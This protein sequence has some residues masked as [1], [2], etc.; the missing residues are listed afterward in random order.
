M[1]RATRRGL[2]G[3]GLAGGA[4]FGLGYGVWKRRTFGRADSLA[5]DVS[6]KAISAFDRTK[7]AQRRFGLLTFRSGLELTS[8]APGFGGWSALWRDPIDPRLVAVSDHGQWL[9]ARIVYGDRVLAGLADAR[10]SPV[11]GQDGAPLGAGG[12]YDCESLAIGGGEAFVGVERT[13]RVLRFAWEASGIGARG[14]PMTLPEE[15]GRQPRNRGIEALCIAP[16]GHPLAG[17]LIAFAEAAPSGDEDPSPGWVLTGPE[18][19]GFHV[20]RSHDFN[21]TDALILP[22]GELIL[23]ERSFTPLRGVGCRLRRIARD[24]IRPGAMLDGEVL[25][26]ADRGFEI[27]NMEGIAAHRDP[28]SGETVLTLMS[29][30]NFMPFQRTL[31]LEFALAG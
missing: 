2:I 12:D 29:D 20:A 7:P 25:M 11:L 31:L 4:A 26:Q 23:L 1:R 30:D 6:A 21:V 16:A 5:A 13:H 24:A 14:V 28:G 22:S 9:T 18:R 27:D 19:F 10:L 15:I 3:L 17:A 8:G